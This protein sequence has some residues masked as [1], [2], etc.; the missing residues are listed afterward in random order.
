MTQDGRD[1]VKYGTVLLVLSLM[2]N[3]L[4]WIFHVFI[5]RGLGPVGYGNYAVVLAW[6]IIFVYP[7][8]ALQIAVADRASRYRAK[9]KDPAISGLMRKMMQLTALSLL[10]AIV[11]AAIGGDALGGLMNLRLG[12]MWILGFLVVAAVLMTV[13]RGLL[14]GLQ[15]FVALGLNIFVDS[16]VRCL[17]G[18][19]LIYYLHY[20]VLVALG[21]SIF[22]AIISGICGIWILRNF[23]LQRGR[24][25]GSELKRMFRSFLPML[26]AMLFFGV[27]TNADIQMVKEFFP[28]LD[29]GYYAAAHKV[30]EIFIYVP[31]AI[32]G[33]MFPKV[34]ASSERGE[35]TK[36]L[37]V[38]SMVYACLICLGGGIVCVFFPEFVTRM[39]FGEAFVPGS[40]MVM[41]FPF[42]FTPFSL[43]NIVISYLIARRRFMFC[44]L[45]GGLALLYLGA[46]ALFHA[47]IQAIMW[48]EF[49]AGIACLISLLAFGQRFG[50]RA[51]AA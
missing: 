2:A 6:F 28:E 11:V 22:S 20:G 16:F 50:K 44:Y 35:K 33:V 9:K 40:W 27:M 25:S 29:V 18:A 46:L 19:L 47:S 12:E 7:L 17:C 38:L 14:Q 45:L 43:A 13:V 30:G 24:M 34:A 51:L 4:Q 3:A 5:S 37:L 41:Y 10:V 49:S 23:V 36:H 26:L 32:I 42:V 15:R 39:I 8:S 48:V 1:I 21:S 31:M